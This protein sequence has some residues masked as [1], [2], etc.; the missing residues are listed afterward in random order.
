MS[1]TKIWSPA[2]KIPSGGQTQM[3]ICELHPPERCSRA[4][5][6]AKKTIDIYL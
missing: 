5:M 2:R 4:G 1:M 3:K 6:T